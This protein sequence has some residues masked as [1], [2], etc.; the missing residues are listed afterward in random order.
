[1]KLKRIMTLLL[2]LSLVISS[3]IV[4]ERIDSIKTFAVSNNLIMPVIIIDA[5]HGNFDGGA[6]ANDGTVEKDI[7]L[8][9]AKSLS[10]ICNLN[11]LITEMV[12][13]EDSSLEDEEDTSIRERKNSD[14]RNRRKLMT[15]Y[16]NTLYISIH[17]NKFSDKS[18]RGAQVFYSPEFEN[19]KLLAKHIQDAVKYVQEDNNRVIKKGTKDAYLLYNAECPA[20]IVE[21]GFLSNP[22]D[23]ENLKNDDY[24]QKMAFSIYIGIINYLNGE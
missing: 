15:K 6:V 3:A 5:G 4:M 9:V 21:C 8:K 20:V 1:M 22:T 16:E 23:L 10:S 12:R 7:N 18:V 2:G 11:G 17:M 14:L 24:L 19:A 13:D